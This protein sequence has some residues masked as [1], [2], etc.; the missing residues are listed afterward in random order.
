MP[1][2]APGAKRPMRKFPPAPRREEAANPDPTPTSPPD[3]DVAAF[4]NRTPSPAPVYTSEHEPEKIQP[5]MLPFGNDAFPAY[6]LD[7]AAHVTGADAVAPKA[8]AMKP[9]AGAVTGGEVCPLC[10]HTQRPVLVF[11]GPVA[12]NICAQCGEHYPQR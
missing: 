4:H 2:G 8:V 1:R 7:N 6:L 10:G 5:R 12:M 11:L 3:A 9:V